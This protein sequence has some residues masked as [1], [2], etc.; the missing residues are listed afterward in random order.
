VVFPGSWI[1]EGKYNLEP[2]KTY[3]A[4]ARHRSRWDIPSLGVALP[5][6]NALFMARE[7]LGLMAPAEKWPW[8][9][10][11][12][13]GRYVLF[14]NRD[15]PTP[16]QWKAIKKACKEKKHDVIVIFPEGTTSIDRQVHPSFIRLAKDH[17]LPLLPINIIPS[18]CYGKE[19]GEKLRHVLC[20]R[21]RHT[22]IRI[23]KSFNYE[24]LLEKLTSELG[25]DAVETLD[26]KNLEKK[27]A[28]LAM[29]IT[30]QA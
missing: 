11:K 14:V 28:E 18:G 20:G 5:T 3:L 29:K 27:L 26:H 8:F 2:G 17:D 6:N 13:E 23:G 15:N 22:S 7:G 10:N 9:R 24:E 12:V 4:I 21:A 19:N 30:D 25:N 16:S 1:V